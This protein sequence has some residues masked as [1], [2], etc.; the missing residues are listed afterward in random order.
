MTRSGRTDPSATLSEDSGVMYK[1]RRSFFEMRAQSYIA[2]VGMRLSSRSR[3]TRNA[4]FRGRE[5][6]DEVLRYMASMACLEFFQQ[7]FLNKGPALEQSQL[8]A[9]QQRRGGPAESK[10]FLVRHIS[11]VWSHSD[12]DTRVVVRAKAQAIQ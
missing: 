2:V 4:M 6:M 12:M 11:C 7:Q 9:H 8:G 1:T 10:W 3:G 5:S